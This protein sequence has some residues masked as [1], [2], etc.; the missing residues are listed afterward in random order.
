M[1]NHG[2]ISRGGPTALIVD[3]DEFS[4]DILRT[5]LKMAGCAVLEVVQGMEAI[6]M[7]Q[8]ERPSLIFLDYCLPGMDGSQVCQILKS[9]P[10]TQA[11]PIIIISGLD[12]SHCLALGGSQGAD[13]FMAKP[14]EAS[15]ITEILRKF[16]PGDRGPDHGR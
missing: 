6:A 10:R 4:R 16:L 7:A 15:A 2:G 12:Q 5:R 11:I 3:D 8:R 1:H 14:W 9:D 13:A